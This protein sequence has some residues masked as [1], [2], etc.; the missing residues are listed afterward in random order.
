MREWEW[1]SSSG[2]GDGVGLEGN[3]G[4]VQPEKERWLDAS[5]AGAPTRIGGERYQEE[6]EVW[7]RAF[8]VWGF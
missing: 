1:S 3:R 2:A 8:T 5:L 4:L 7:V 6:E